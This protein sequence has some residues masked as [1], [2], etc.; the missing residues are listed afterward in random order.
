GMLLASRMVLQVPFSLYMTQVFGA[1]HWVTGLSYGLL[2][3][4]FVVGAPFWARLFNGRAKSYVLGWSV[5]ISA[6]CLAITH[7]AGITGS[8]AF[9]AMLYFVWGALLGGTTPALLSLISAA[10]QNDRQG[11]VLGL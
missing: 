5:L 3:L 6:G 9:F 7:L 2:A 4:G 11:S 8:I 10:T 1:Q